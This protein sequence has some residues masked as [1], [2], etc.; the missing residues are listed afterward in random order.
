MFKRFK[1]AKADEKIHSF[2]RPDIKNVFVQKTHISELSEI[3]KI[4]A[5]SRVPH[6]SKTLLRTVLKLDKLVLD[7]NVFIIANIVLN[8]LLESERPCKLFYLVLD[9]LCSSKNSCSIKKI[10][11]DYLL[12]QLLSSRTYTTFLEYILRHFSESIQ[13]RE[14]DIIK[15]I[16]N[17]TLKSRVQNLMKKNS[18]T[19]YHFKDQIY[20]LRP[21]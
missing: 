8:L 18:K 12:A 13:G 9:R 15:C 5:L 2:V 4:I 19:T 1:K 14:I 16:D 3:N 10:C 6:K 17:P 7:K 21:C 11:A 20:Y